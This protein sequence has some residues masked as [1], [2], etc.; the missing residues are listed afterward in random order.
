[1]PSTNELLGIV[2]SGVGAPTID[3]SFF[4]NTQSSVYW[5]GSTF[6]SVPTSAEYVHF[7][8]GVADH[9]IKTGAHQV[10]LVR[11]GPAFATSALSVTA[12]G[13]GAGS[14]TS[15]GINCARAANSTTGTCT[16]GRGT[17]SVVTLT[18][19]ATTGNVFAGWSGGVCSGTSSACT[20]TLGSVLPMDK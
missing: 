7:S 5:S 8:N 15:G 14:V 3:I 2:K 1:M 10:R 12:T 9:L 4:P 20:L 16:V 6:A 11:G 17:N 19:S 18:A 13:S